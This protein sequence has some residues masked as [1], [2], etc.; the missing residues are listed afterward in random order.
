MFWSSD[1]ASPATALNELLKN[2]TATLADV[3]NDE[4]VIQ[5]I[6]I[7]NPQLMK[8]LTRQEV[9][10]QLVKGALEPE[11]DGSLPLKEQYKKSHLCAEILSVNNEELS[12]AV[13]RNEEAC[14]L[15]FDFLNTKKLNHVLAGFYMKIVSKYTDQVSIKFLYKQLF[16]FHLKIMRHY[17]LFEENMLFNRMKE[18]QFLLYCM[19]SMK[20]SAVAEL[21]YRIATSPSELDQLDHIKQWLAESRLVENLCDLLVPEQPPVVHDNVGHLWSELVRVLRD[22][23]YTAE[24]KRSDFLLESLQSERNV[25]HL[26]SRMLPDSIDQRRDS[27][28][29]NCA[30]ILIVLLE[31][32]FVPNCPSRQLGME[33]R[34][35]QAQWCGVVPITGNEVSCTTVWQPDAGRIVET[36]VAAFGDRIV[37][38]ILD[39]VKVGDGDLRLCS[40][41]WCPLMRLLVLVL[42]TNHLPTHQTLLAAFSSLSMNPFKLFLT[43]VNTRPQLTVFQNLLHRAVAYILFTH[44]SPSSPLIKYLIKDVDILKHT[45]AGCETSQADF[46][47]GYSRRTLH[48]FYMNLASL[49][50]SASE[51]SVNAE[52]ITQLLQGTGQTNR[53]EALLKE[54]KNYEEKNRADDTGVTPPPASD[55]V[56]KARIDACDFP[57]LLGETAQVY[58]HIL[59]A[60][61]LFV[62]ILDQYRQCALLQTPPED[63]PI[64]FPCFSHDTDY[65]IPDITPDCTIVK[66]FTSI[67]NENAFDA[68][69]TLRIDNS[70]TNK[71]V[72]DG[73]PSV[74]NPKGMEKT[75]DLKDDD[76]ISGNFSLLWNEAAPGSTFKKFAFRGAVGTYEKR[77]PKEIT[78]KEEK[79]ISKCIID[80]IWPETSSSSAS[81]DF[82]NWADF[83]SIK[84]DDWPPMENHDEKS[85]WDEAADTIVPSATTGGAVG[86]IASVIMAENVTRYEL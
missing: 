4:Y 23:Q 31:T 33:D 8:F 21:L 47:H 44:S 60:A 66:D 43:Y 39:S 58:F 35:I 73:W 54:V 5:E 86:G 17:F 80:D 83:S 46:L 3:L 42:D 85:A 10:V 67:G 82:G 14:C 18:S 72:D 13:V 45:L 26:M 76:P 36:V 20:Y 79:K 77:A 68:M 62:H 28:I 50:R 19:K 57:E 2:D 59:L 16:S 37:N 74:S 64:P 1:L 56:D 61:L 52:L 15:L 63:I 38:A 41:A 7:S 55:V 69:C 32:N 30:A 81:A 24:C 53:W 34:G 29:V 25:R 84:S 65:E 49:I 6:R 27:V 70:I 12:K 9:V 22:A 71:D 75:L 11:I 51:S 40:D 78:T 48:S